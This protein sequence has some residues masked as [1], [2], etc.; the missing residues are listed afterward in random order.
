MNQNNAFWPDADVLRYR[1]S[2][3]TFALFVHKDRLVLVHD[4]VE[5]EASPVS[6][7]AEAQISPEGR[8][9][10]EVPW[11]RNAIF[12]C[13]FVKKKKN[14]CKD[15]LFSNILVQQSVVC[16]LIKRWSLYQC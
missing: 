7:G 6:L 8:F 15:Q 1:L 11:H 4:V 3:L 16:T 9:E 10:G 12:S 2:S 13:K 5:E 14:R